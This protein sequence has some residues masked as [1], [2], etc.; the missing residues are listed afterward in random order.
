MTNRHATHPTASNAQ[1]S[2]Y[3]A[4]KKAKRKISATCVL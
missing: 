1:Q 3:A 2:N 4:V